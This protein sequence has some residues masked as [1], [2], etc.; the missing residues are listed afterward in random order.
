MLA[1]LVVYVLAFFF[2]WYGSGLIVTA[3]GRFSKKLHVSPFLFSFLFL[4]LLTQI[5]EFSVGLQS[6]ASGHP[7]VFVGNLLGGVIV[8]M[9]VVV[10]LLAVVGNGISVKNEIKGKPLLLSLGVV[11]MPAY[12]VLD[13]QVTNLEGLIMLIAYVV[14]VLFIQRDGGI[15]DKDNKKTMKAKN[16]SYLDLLK[17]IVGL[18]IVFVA[19]NILLEKTLFFA[20]LLGI[21]AFYVSLIVVAL[22]T[23]APELILA[24]RS[25]FG[26]SRDVAMGD[27]LGGAAASTLLFGV[28]TLLNNGRVDQVNN[29]L[30]TFVFIVIALGLYY[31]FSKS[32]QY[33]S[34]TEGLVM[35]GVYICFLVVEIVSKS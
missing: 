17:L 13:K 22:G 28:F 14:L 34:R 30:V 16:F 25:A 33:I 24:V 23:D 21:S 35:F 15:L 9:L 19:S 8:L 7:E 5:P 12:F 3:A 11:A 4:G 20:N 6:I 1:H 2:I 31:V 26:K 32:K 10:P 18:G 27:Y 29:F